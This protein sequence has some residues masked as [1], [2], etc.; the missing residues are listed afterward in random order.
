[1]GAA[2]L[3]DGGTLFLD[4]IGE[5][6]LDMQVKLLR[7]V[8]TGSFTPVGSSRIERVD[9][10]FV[11]ATNRDPMLEVQAGRF[12]EDLYYRLY[13]VPIELPP[14]R[15]RGADVIAIAQHFLAQFSKEEK[16]KFKGFAPDA[17]AALMAYN[18]PGNI[19]QLQ[20]AIRNVVVLNRDGDW[21]DAGMLP[22]P[23]V[24]FGGAAAVQAPPIAPPPVR[25]P[26]PPAPVAAAPQ[27]QD[28]RTQADASVAVSGSRSRLHLC[29]RRR[30]HLLCRRRLHLLRPRRLYLLQRRLPH[31]LHLAQ[32][33]TRTTTRSCRSR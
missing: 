21:V 27:P 28:P 31:R 8:Q 1:M 13:V 6:P 11:C 5:M 32:G 25:P 2:K 19:R 33:P 14:L 26:A 15:E 10:R 20:N 18:W 24:R 4:E 12:R 7:F 29:R 17:V 16:R 22:P 23:V 3:A 9:T 30:L